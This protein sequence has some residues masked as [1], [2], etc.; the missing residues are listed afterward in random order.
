[1]LDTTNSPPVLTLDLLSV[2]DLDP[3]KV[4]ESA[5]VS[6]AVGYLA[7]DDPDTGPNADVTCTSGD[8]H[9]DLQPLNT[10]AYKVTS[11]SFRHTLCCIFVLF[12]CLFV[13]FLKT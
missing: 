6:T 13:C 3:G 5:K 8:P 1:M 2:D 12:F 11:L 7:V 9:F 4:P 10:D